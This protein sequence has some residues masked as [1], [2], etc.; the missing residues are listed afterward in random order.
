MECAATYVEYGY[1][2]ILGFEWSVPTLRRLR[3]RGLIGVRVSYDVQVNE[4]IG[5]EPQRRGKERS[6]SAPPRCKQ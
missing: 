4:C 2:C 5:V 3:R 1:V 6:D